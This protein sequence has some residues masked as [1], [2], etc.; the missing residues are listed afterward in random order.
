MR[1]G[2]V[3]A[4]AGLAASAVRFY[5]QAGLLPAPPRTPARY[6]DYPPETAVRLRFIRDAQAAGLTLAD[7]RGVLAVRDAG[8][9]PCGHV[10]PL[11]HA[12]I[13]Q[14]QQRISELTAARAILRDLARRAAATDPADCT[15]SDICSILT[16][17]PGCADSQDRQPAHGRPRARR[18]GS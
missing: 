16:R 9:P 10:I 5:E 1:I 6:R 18:G 4:S 13:D 7:I 15:E 14:I 17:H 2:E 8:N 11:I 12:H 3:A